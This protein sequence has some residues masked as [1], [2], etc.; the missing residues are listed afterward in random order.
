MGT[1]DQIATSCGLSSF[2]DPT[3]KFKCAFAQWSDSK[4]TVGA[5][6]GPTVADGVNTFGY[7]EIAYYIS[8]AA[9]DDINA[10]ADNLY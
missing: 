3:F 5:N 7:P 8:S 1:L 2:T 10:I 9:K 6:Q 4:I